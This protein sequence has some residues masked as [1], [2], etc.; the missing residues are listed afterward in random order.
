MVH[1]CGR[2][3]AVARFELGNYD[4]RMGSSSELPFFDHA[5]LEELRQRTA[6]ESDLQNLLE[7]FLEPGV[8]LEAFA[9]HWKDYADCPQSG[10]AIARA[11]QHAFAETGDEELSSE[12]FDRF[13]N[14]R[15][16]VVVH[17]DLR[18][19][20]EAWVKTHLIVTGSLYADALITGYD[21]CVAICGDVHVRGLGTD[22]ALYIGGA[23]NASDLVWTYGSG[24]TTSAQSC[25]TRLY[26][27]EKHHPDE[28]G[29]VDADRS[30]EVWGVDDECK[31][32]L[33]DLVLA[34]VLDGE[35]FSYWGLTQ[36]LGQ[37]KPIFLQD[38]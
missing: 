26:I 7:G 30:L 18:V 9:A 34:E 23:L 35:S 19:T 8:S 37:G 1:G 13:R 4:P 14:S 11:L 32:E 22:G 38:A 17:G 3:E 15:P 29:S 12:N 21:H 24:P 31:D 36:R 2:A 16:L 28:F 20:G 33:R 6:A 27:N 5:R 10:L 25:K